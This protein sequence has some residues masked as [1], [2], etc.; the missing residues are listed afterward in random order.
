MFCFVLFPSVRFSLLLCSHQFF[1]LLSCAIML[2]YVMFWFCSAQFPYVQL[3][4]FMFRYATLCVIPMSSAMLRSVMFC[5]VLLWSAQM[6]SSVFVFSCPVFV[7]FCLVMFC[8][9]LFSSVHDN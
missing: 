4:A 9:V 5:A 1:S 2:N 6:C 8:S 3:S 7:L